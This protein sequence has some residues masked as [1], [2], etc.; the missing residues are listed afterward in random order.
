MPVKLDLVL[1]L[2]FVPRVHDAEGQLTVIGEEQQT[3]AWPIQPADRLYPLW[4]INKIH[5]RLPATLVG[6]CSDVALGLVEQDIALALDPH[7]LTIECDA[8]P[9]RV[10][11]RPQFSDDAAIDANPA[12]YDH[13]LGLAPR[14]NARTRQHSLETLPAGVALGGSV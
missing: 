11:G 5:H 3:F 13:L 1:L 2:D 9:L 12:R 8:L 14:G 7:C 6:Y 10:H 4:N